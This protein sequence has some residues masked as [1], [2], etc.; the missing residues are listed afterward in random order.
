M[1][2]TTIEALFA[3]TVLVHR[4][5]LL[6]AATQMTRSP[7]EAE[8][9]VQETLVKAF[10]AFDRL[11][12]GSQV[13]AWLLR[14]LRNTH[15]SE[16]RKRRRERTAL[17]Q[18]AEEEVA[19]WLRSSAQATEEGAPFDGNGL[20]DEVLAALEAVPAPYRTC[21]ILVDLQQRSYREAAALTSQP[22]GTIQ[23]RL[24]R[25]R[26]LLQGLL[27]DYA[28]REGYLASAA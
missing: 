16:W 1:D 14:I 9:L 12:P 24:F 4:P 21:V 15:I 6:R 3:R 18:G 2:S 7:S 5:M 11:R 8:D 23:S 20:D 26:R 10:R 19:S 28:Q 13:R 17:E 27:K 25:G 22:L